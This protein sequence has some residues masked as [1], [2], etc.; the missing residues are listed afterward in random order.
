MK[1]YK[2][3][4]NGKNIIIPLCDGRNDDLGDFL[5]QVDTL[6]LTKEISLKIEN[7]ARKRTM[8]SN[9]YY[10]V[11]RR[12]IAK[13]MGIGET[14]Y[15]NRALAEVGIAVLDENGERDWTWKLES[16]NYLKALDGED[17]Y[18]PTSD[19]VEYEGETFRLHYRLKST[20]D[21]DTKEFNQL[22]EYAIADA[23]EL[24]IESRTPEQIRRDAWMDG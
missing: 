24:G 12:R 10:H 11:L 6:D 20:R 15:H 7:K 2:P 21:F 4:I 13:A 16:Y 3:Y 22:L 17:H 9:A 19:M 1:I 5:S 23:K 8:D 18:A 14:E